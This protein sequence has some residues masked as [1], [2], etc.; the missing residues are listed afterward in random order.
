MDI[1]SYLVYSCRKWVNG[2]LAYYLLTLLGS[3]IPCSVPVWRSS[4]IGSNA[5]RLESIGENEVWEGIPAG[6]MG[7]CGG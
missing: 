3:E 5:V 6:Y 7:T 1:Y 2:H 4:V